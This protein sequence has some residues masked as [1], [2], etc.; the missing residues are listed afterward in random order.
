V[1]TQ[2]SLR[3]IA[4][5]KPPFF[6]KTLQPC[7]CFIYRKTCPDEREQLAI[8]L[9]LWLRDDFKNYGRERL[10]LFRNLAVCLHE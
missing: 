3:P 10:K 8:V 1:N 7:E 4:C 9:R 6:I 2:L 5:L